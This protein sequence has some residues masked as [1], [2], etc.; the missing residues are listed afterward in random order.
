MG[1][2]VSKGSEGA[3]EV[4]RSEPLVYVVTP[5]YLRAM[6]TGLRGRDFTWD[7]GPKS[8]NVVMINESFARFLAGYAHWQNGDAV[9][10]MLSG[11]GT[12]DARVVGVVDDVHEE[13]VEGDAGWQIY[14]PATQTTPNEAQLVL[15]TTTAAGR[16]GGECAARAA[17]IE[18]RS[19]LRRSFSR[20]RCW[21]ITRTRRG[22]FS[23]CWLGRLRGWGCCWLRWGFME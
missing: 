14:Y 20:S 1:I 13:N 21:W 16:A 7:D 6:G 15:R 4:D 3:G 22:D 5:G 18:S 17:G 10:E 23:C 12:G 8:A 2:A 11:S 19:S 9:G